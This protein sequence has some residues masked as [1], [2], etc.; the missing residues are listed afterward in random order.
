MHVEHE[1]A[2]EAFTVA[3]RSLFEVVETLSDEDQQAASYC[4]GWTVG[5]VLTHLHLGLQEMLLGVVSP[6]DAPTDTDAASYWRGEEWTNDP[7]ADPIAHVRFV[8]LLAAAYRRPAGLI[9]HM[10]P[11][12]DALAGAVD[13][14]EEG[15]VAFQNRVLTS[16]DFLATWVFEVAVHHLDLTRELDLPAP[17][18]SALR[19]TRQTV[20]ALAGGALPAAWSDETA[21]LL[22]AGRVPL[23]D[24]Q[25]AAA[26]TVAERLP[27]L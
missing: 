14:M 8:R 22:G 26:G 10:R 12:V 19:I 16:G 25:H 5:D 1:T 4:R 17:P 3:L 15:R 13:R 20:E 21:A 7:Q 18:E 6:T 11:T 2:Q 9:G 24:Q 23:S 27:V